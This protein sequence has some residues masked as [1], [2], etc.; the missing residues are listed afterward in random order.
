MCGIAGFSGRP[1]VEVSDAVLDRIGHRGPDGRERYNSACGSV[2]LFHTRL[3]ILDPT[4][5]GAQPMAA[6]DGQAVIAFNG[7]IYNFRELHAGLQKRGYTFSSHTDTE[8]LLALYL[9]H[10]TALLERLNGIY[11]FALWDARSKSLFV[12][13]DGMGVKPLYIS[14]FGG[15][16][17][18]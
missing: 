1:A 5:E 17:A 2:S 16:F 15:A 8:V 9:E 18:F 10:G 11:A 6:A 13:R 7:E 12:A 14:E 4:P 3:A